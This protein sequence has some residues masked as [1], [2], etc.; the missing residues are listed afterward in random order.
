MENEEAVSAVANT[1][2]TRYDKFTVL[3]PSSIVL[4]PISHDLGGSLLYHSHA[5]L[6]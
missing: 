4:F 6:M 3:L 5:A 1:G 2:A